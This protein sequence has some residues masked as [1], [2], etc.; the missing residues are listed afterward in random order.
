MYLIY[1]LLPLKDTSSGADMGFSHH[2]QDS[3]T[4]IIYRL[5]PAIYKTLTYV[6][7]SCYFIT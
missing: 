5:E 6:V 2:Y 7:T 1:C 3:L 4:V